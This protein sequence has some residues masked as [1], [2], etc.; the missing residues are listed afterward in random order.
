VFCDDGVV[1][2]HGAMIVA[3]DFG[4]VNFDA[5]RVTNEHCSTIAATT[6]GLVDIAYSDVTNTHNSFIEATD[7]GTV[8]FN[9]AWVTN[10]GDSTMEAKGHH[11]T[12]GLEHT[13][14]MNDGGTIA[15]IGCDAR[16]E[17]IDAT[18]VGGTL[19][20]RD[21]AIIE[22]VGGTST[23]DGITIA[24]GTVLQAN[25]GTDVD[26]KETITVDGT[27]TL[28]GCGTFTLD[29]PGAKIIGDTGTLDNLGTI[30]GAGT[31]GNRQL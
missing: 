11:S 9:H 8:I 7:G 31:I 28:Q 6:G 27:V 26:L 25:H 3:A 13:V 5:D 4:T 18:I 20:S 2:Q 21:G 10:T 29:G 1:N 23:L 12:V 15:A 14:V 16:V 19:E 30:D 22:N 17:L 24:D